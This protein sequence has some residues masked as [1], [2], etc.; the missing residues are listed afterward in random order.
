[1]KTAEYVYLAVGCGMLGMGLT[2]VMLLVCLY[3]GIDISRN[4]WVITIPIVGTITLNILLIE[5][6]SRRR[7]K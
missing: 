5:L 7:K 2:Y 1:V 6:L 4:L 3:Y